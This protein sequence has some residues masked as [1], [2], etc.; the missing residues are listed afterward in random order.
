MQVQITR[1]GPCIPVADHQEEVGVWA[2]KQAPPGDILV[3]A[4]K[5]APRGIIGL[6]PRPRTLKSWPLKT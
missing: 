2:Y 3:Q 5:Q 4:I 1:P 6:A